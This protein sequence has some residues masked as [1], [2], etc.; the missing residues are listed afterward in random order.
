VA[1]GDRVLLVPAH[2]AP[3]VA[4]HEVLWVAD[5]PDLDAEVIDRWSIDL[6]HW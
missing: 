1:V 3:T 6:R 5:G 2:L 4:R